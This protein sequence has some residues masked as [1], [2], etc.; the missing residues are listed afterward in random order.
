[1]DGRTDGWTD[2]RTDR[3]A[4]VNP[5]TRA[6]L[7]FPPSARSIWKSCVAERLHGRKPESDAGKPRAPSPQ[8]GLAFK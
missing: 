4:G 5:R 6:R 7:T 1:M 2:G 8:E 3:N